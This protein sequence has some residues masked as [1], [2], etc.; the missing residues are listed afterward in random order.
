MQ[1]LTL[2]TIQ[3]I[4]K[5]LKAKPFAVIHRNLLIL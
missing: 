5:H 4:K 2:I 1:K 3:A